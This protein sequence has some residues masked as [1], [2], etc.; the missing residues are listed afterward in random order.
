[1]AWAVLAGVVVALAAVSPAPNIAVRATSGLVKV[2][3]NDRGF[4]P[5]SVTVA[6]DAPVELEFLRT[7]DETCASAVAFPE[8]GITEPLAI[9]KPVRIKVPVSQPRTLSFQCGVGDHRSAVIIN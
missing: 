2:E 1:M 5:S 4:S 9:N 6:P 3:V 7:T 8:L